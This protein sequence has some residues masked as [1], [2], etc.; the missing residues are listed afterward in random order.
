MKILVVD[1][2]NLTLHYT[3]PFCNSLQERGHSVKLV[4]SSNNMNLDYD[5]Q[6]FS[7]F[8][9]S[10]IFFPHKVIKFI[11]YII[12]VF[13]TISFIKNHKYDVVHFQMTPLPL[14]DIFLI[15]LIRN[16]TQI[17]ATIHNTTP[18]HGNRVSLIQTIGFNKL[19]FHYNF[20]ICH[21]SYSANIL[22]ND[23]N[24]SSKKIYIS[25]HPLFNE[26]KELVLS[27]SY[28]LSKTNNI[29][30]FGTLSEYKGI[31]VLLKAFSLLPES[32]KLHTILTIAGKPLMN[33][34]PLQA[35]AKDLKINEF[36]EW[37]IGWIQNSEIDNLFDHSDLMIMPYTHIDASGVLVKAMEFNIPVIASNLGG[38]QELINNK[39]TG[40]LFEPNNYKELSEHIFNLL[41][42]PSI[43]EN[44]RKSINSKAL[45]L[46][47]W[48]DL[49]NTC[50]N[51]YRNE[52]QG[53][54]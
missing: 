30:F 12:G 53:D 45:S 4:C 15:K 28:S 11:N 47:T 9:L 25:D 37:K 50:V 35:L 46:H 43:K 20:L 49:A 36:I 14:L 29:L 42:N 22:K 54:I 18:F 8:Y 6:F 19:L 52:P 33:I 51:A 13:K 1:A 44:M 3:V 39:E 2:A 10:K 16:H 38:F 48:D 40:L 23:F 7:Y 31:D 21:T 41:Q 34:E 17:G 5:L 27:K 24:I 26:P 32:L